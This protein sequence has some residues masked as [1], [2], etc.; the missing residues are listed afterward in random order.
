MKKRKAAQWLGASRN[1]AAIQRA[2]GD[3]HLITA[4]NHTA[5]KGNG[6]AGN[7]YTPYSVPRGN[8]HPLEYGVLVLHVASR[9][10]RGMHGGCVASVGRLAT[11]TAR[12]LATNGHVRVLIMPN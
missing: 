10:G 4:W 7:S 5:T 11:R 3:F 2:I 6:A 12:V 1:G 9:V 8:S